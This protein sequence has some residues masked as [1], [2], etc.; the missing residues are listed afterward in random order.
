MSRNN[1]PRGNLRTRPSESELKV[2]ERLNT[3]A[4]WAE[5]ISRNVLT[6]C[7]YTVP[8]TITYFITDSVKAIAGTTT[9]YNVVFNFLA[10]LNANQWFAYIFGAAGIGFG[11][12]ERNL[13]KKHVKRSSTRISKL[14]HEINPRRSSSHLTPTGDTRQGDE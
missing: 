1:T 10:D 11:L 7:K 8:I 5:A 4:I 14:E 9:N 3:K 2:Q 12:Y 13:R 6:I